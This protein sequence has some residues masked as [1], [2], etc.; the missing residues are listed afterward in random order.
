[1]YT[2]S[3][4]LAE[5][6]PG[7]A[8]ILRTR[9]DG[10]PINFVDVDE[11]VGHS[12]VHYL[13]TGQYQT[14]MAP[15]SSATSRRQTEYRQSVHIYSVA[16][17]YKIEG[18]D[19]LAKH[20]MLLF[21]DSVDIFQILS[22]AKKE[23]EDIRDLDDWYTN[24]LVNKIQTAF[25]EDEDVFK[26]EE[27]SAILGEVAKFD[28][29]LMQI[30]ISLYLD[31]VSNL[32]ERHES[33]KRVVN[34]HCMEPE[35]QP[36]HLSVE[37]QSKPML[38][39]CLDYSPDFQTMS[40]AETEYGSASETM[41]SEPLPDRD[42]LVLTPIETE[43]VDEGSGYESQTSVVDDEEIREMARQARKLVGMIGSV[44]D[45]MEAGT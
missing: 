41:E 13:Y 7:V 4:R 16:L 42:C 28:Q 8:N 45:E 5:K 43:S 12:V 2:I 40:Q 35:P 27:F 19:A 3:E 36:E 34:S 39:S 21:E 14:I 25:E 1:M 9:E 24:Y 10:P 44:A 22:V 33:E 31:K 32:K 20:Y 37:A 18:L 30:V 17:G 29:F 15:S 11:D 6:I 26:R 38:D 23:Y